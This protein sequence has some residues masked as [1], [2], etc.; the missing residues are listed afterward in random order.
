MIVEHLGK[1][2][3]RNFKPKTVKKGKETTERKKKL[4]KA[5]VDQNENLSQMQKT[6]QGKKLSLKVT[7]YLDKDTPDKTSFKKDLDNMLKILMDVIKEEM[8]DNEKNTGL[9][10]VVENKDEEV[11]EVVCN[12]ELVS[13]EDKEGID[14]DIF[15]LD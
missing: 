10:L 11:F 2:F 5:F 1:L 8:D 4:K 14:L 13:G 9:G 6:C 15:E 7:F 3:V 12:K